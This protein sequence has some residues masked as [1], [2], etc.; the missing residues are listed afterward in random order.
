MLMLLVALA[1][2]SAS[3]SVDA[4]R[5]ENDKVRGTEK[6]GSEKDGS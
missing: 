6:G 4:S 1:S 3:A 2:A 5:A